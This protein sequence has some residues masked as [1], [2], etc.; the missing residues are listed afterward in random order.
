MKQSTSRGNQEMC[1]LQISDIIIFFLTPPPPFQSCL[2]PLLS[3]AVN[4]MSKLG[5]FET[6]APIKNVKL[7]PVCPEIH[8][9]PL[10]VV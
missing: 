5:A 3:D 8:I 4:I 2:P 1:S 9:F 7:E 6:T 10:T